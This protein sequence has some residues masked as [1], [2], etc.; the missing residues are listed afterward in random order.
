MTATKITPKQLNDILNILIYSELSF[1]CAE[2]PVWLAH[3]PIYIVFAIP[4]SGV[5]VT[6]KSIFTKDESQATTNLLKGK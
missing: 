1:A 5:L 6:L 3:N 4:I 2:L